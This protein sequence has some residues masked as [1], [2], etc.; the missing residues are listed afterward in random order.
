KRQVVQRGMTLVC[1][2]SSNVFLLSTRNS[3]LKVKIQK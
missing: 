2:L 3:S 1:C